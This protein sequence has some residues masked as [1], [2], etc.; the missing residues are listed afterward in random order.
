VTNACVETGAKRGA[1]VPPLF[2]PKHP[3]NPCHSDRREESVISFKNDFISIADAAQKFY[4]V[5]RDNIEERNL[6][7]CDNAFYDKSGGLKW[8]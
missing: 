5:H 6:N 3:A 4:P 2:L 1:A 7:F 8:Y